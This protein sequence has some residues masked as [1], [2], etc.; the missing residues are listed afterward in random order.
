MFCAAH[1]SSAPLPGKTMATRRRR[2]K[3]K[4]KAKK[5][6]AHPHEK[7]LVRSGLAKSNRMDDKSRKKLAKLTKTEVK[8]LVSAK[9]KLGFKGTLHG[10]SGDFL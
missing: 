3:P 9:R 6:A 8:S 7:A 2:A 10:K 5:A 4:A 1:M